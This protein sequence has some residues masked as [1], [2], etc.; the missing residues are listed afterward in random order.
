[1]IVQNGQSSKIAVTRPR[2]Y[3]RGIQPNAAVWPGFEQRVGKIEEG[4]SLDFSPLLSL[5]GK[6]I[7]AVIKYEINQVEKLIN[8][9]VEVPNV[10]AP[11]QRAEIQVPQLASWKLQERFTWPTDKVLLISGGIVAKPV[12]AQEGSFRIPLVTAPPRA[13]CLVFIESKGEIARAA[14]TIKTAQ[15]P[16]KT[17]HGRY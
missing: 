7:D 1:M 15:Q 6:A 9:G 8:V 4:Y 17:Y 2:T 14:S 13:D 16:A 12:A 5:D 10:V 3:V 11:R